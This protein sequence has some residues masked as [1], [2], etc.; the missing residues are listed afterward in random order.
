MSIKTG[1][2]Y[3]RASL[4]LLHLPLFIRVLYISCGCLTGCLTL[5]LNS[6]HSSSTRGNTTKDFPAAQGVCNCTYSTREDCF[7]DNQ[8]KELGLVVQTSS[9]GTKWLLELRKLTGA[10][11]RAA[12]A[13]YYCRC[14]VR[15]LGWSLG[16]SWQWKPSRTLN[17][18]LVVIFLLF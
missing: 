14:W 6:K 17:T 9:Q 5:C 13:I 1:G 18:S 2:S 7:S 8:A 11:K 15:T 16:Q 3:T 4:I 10:L 12:A